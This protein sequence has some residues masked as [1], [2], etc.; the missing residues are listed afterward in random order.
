MDGDPGLVFSD[1]KPVGLREK[2]QPGH[3][4]KGNPQRNRKSQLPNQGENLDSLLG[5]PTQNTDGSPLT[6]LK[7]FRVQKGEWPTKDVCLTCPD[8]FQETLW[9]D[10]KVLNCRTSGLNRI[11]SN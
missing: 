1:D 8:Q 4:G 6:D 11:R 7:G 2:S 5:H 3:S 10:L 9:I